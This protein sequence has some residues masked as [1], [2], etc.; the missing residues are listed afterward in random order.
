MA[1]TKVLCQKKDDLHSVKLVFCA[2]TKVFEEALNEV[3]FGLAK[4][5]LGLVKGQGISFKSLTKNSYC[6][7]DRCLCFGTFELV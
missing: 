6:S 2:G 5:I 3:K 4:N 1:V 7:N